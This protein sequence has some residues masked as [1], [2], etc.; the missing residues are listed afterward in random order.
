MRVDLER[1][2]SPVSVVHPKRKAVRVGRWLWAA[3]GAVALIS[4]AFLLNVGGLR[5]RIVGPPDPRIDS[6]AV[7]PLDNLSGDPDQDYFADGMTESLITELSKIGSL[8]VIS[9]TS[10]MLYKD[11]EKP[12]PEIA[13]ELNVE[14]VVEGSVLRT[15][16]RVRVTAQLVHAATDQYLWAENFDRDL[17]DILTLYSDVARAIAIE[18]Q[19]KLTA[20]EESLLAHAHPVDPEAIEAYLKGNYYSTRYELAAWLRA[21]DYYEKAIEK[22]PQY[23]A[24]YAALAWYLAVLPIWGGGTAE[25]LYPRAREA[26]QTAIELDDTLARAH[27]TLGWIAFSYSWDWAIAEREFRRAIELEP[28][29]AD[30]HRSYGQYLMWMGRS[31][32]GIAEGRQAVEL[33]PLSLPANSNLGQNFYFARRYDEA[34]EQLTSVLDMEPNY[35]GAHTWLFFTYVK[36]ELYEDA[37]ATCQT[38]NDLEGFTLVNQFCYAY[39]YALWGKREEAMR[40]ITS[41]A[42]A[43]TLESA[44]PRAVI[45]GALGEKDEAFRFLEQALEERDPKLAMAKVDPRLDPLRDDP[46]FEDFVRR[47]DFPE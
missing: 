32:E 4:A 41:P 8:K 47:M 16:D 9:R 12:L 19:I 40:T 24:P 10:A 46:R 6:I 1:I 14:A 15:G 26:A 35:Y 44:W 31:E 20:Q 27:V 13:G 11:S 34:I 25:E 2:S 17:Q 29:S 21:I 43:E 28:G 7:L 37:L 5:D 45:Y 22:D 33:D 36:K 23:A 30:A 38:M 18:I 39:L 42:W 3:A